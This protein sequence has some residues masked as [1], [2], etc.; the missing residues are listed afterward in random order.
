MA[1]VDVTD[2]EWLAFRRMCLD[3]GVPVSAALGPL[4]R[5]ERKRRNAADVRGRAT[6][7]ATE[8]GTLLDA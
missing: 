4:V 7:A 8:A 3:D 6:L 2:L 1:R 5:H